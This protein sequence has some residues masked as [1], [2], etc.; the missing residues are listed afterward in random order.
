MLSVYYATTTAIS[1][2]HMHSGKT[3]CQIQATQSNILNVRVWE[4]KEGNV[5]KKKK[6]RVIDVSG[7]GFIYHFVRFILTYPSSPHVNFNINKIYTLEFPKV[8]SMVFT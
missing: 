7:L 2:Q 1:A 3:P 8:Q 4:G 6:K 5:K